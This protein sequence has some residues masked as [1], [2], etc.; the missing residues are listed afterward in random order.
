VS[1][2][3]LNSVTVQFANELR[4]T[5]FKINAVDPGTRTPT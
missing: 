5:N 1:K 4:G 2:A 3:A